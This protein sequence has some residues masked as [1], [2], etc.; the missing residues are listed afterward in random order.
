MS[1]KR[2]LAVLM[3]AAT[4]ATSVAPV[5]ADTTKSLDGETVSAKDSAKLDQLKKE[6][7]GYLNTK[8]TTNKELLKTDTKAGKCV[9][10]ITSVYTPAS[11]SDQTKVLEST[12]DLERELA[13]LDKADDKI[14][15]TDFLLE[16]ISQVQD[17]IKLKH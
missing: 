5:F 14:S 10:T 9:Y 11:G 12:R 15:I 8:F 6:V 13:K 16:L 1:K 4:V 2:N 3:A 7:E 17:Y